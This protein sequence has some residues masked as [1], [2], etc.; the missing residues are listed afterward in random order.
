MVLDGTHHVG[1]SIESTHNKIDLVLASSDH[2]LDA[3]IF[4][5]ELFFFFHNFCLLENIFLLEDAVGHFYHFWFDDEVFF[6]KDVH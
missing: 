5:A 2:V 6:T 3:S 4:F 1:H